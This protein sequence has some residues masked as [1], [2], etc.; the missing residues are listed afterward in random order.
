MQTVQPN[1]AGTTAGVLGYM[2]WAA[3]RPSVRGVTTQPPDTCEDG[4]GAGATAYSVP[5]PMPA[6]RQS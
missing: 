1:G 3:E 2:F 5:V 4:V 6:L